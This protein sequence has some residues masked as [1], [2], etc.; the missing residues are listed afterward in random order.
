MVA[1]IARMIFQLLVF[2][3]V[4]VAAVYFGQRSLQYFPN[5]T[6]PGEP[7]Q[8]GVPS[9]EIVTL[10][11]DDKLELNAWFA[12]PKNKNGNI[13]ILYHGNA[14]H[15]GH[16][17]IKAQH[18][19]DNGHGV[20]LVDYRGF[21]GNPG[22]PTEQGLYKDGRAAL[23]FLEDKG[24]SP[25]QFVIYG[26]SIGSGVAVQMALEMQPRYLILEAPFSSAAD[27]AKKQYFFLP[28]DLL[29]KDRY[30]NIEK[31]ADVTSSL[32]IIH[33]D[34]D[35]VIP[36]RLGK[37]LYEKANHPK[38][39]VDVNGGNHNNLYEFHAGHIVNDW[40]NKQL[41]QEKKAAEE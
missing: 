29:M 40:L 31:I 8:A 38:E 4:V 36:I 18:F 37:S 32:L 2:Y 16:R 9:M 28:I 41:A 15:I 10:V 17:A 19:I 3:L 23:R 34:E 33:G 1:I 14:G 21:G 30:D 7:A 25:A 26:E 5:R 6:N 13:V 20:L 27:V 11:T 35:V 12:A 39:F 24:Y 22:K